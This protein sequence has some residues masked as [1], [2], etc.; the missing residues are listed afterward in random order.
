MRVCLTILSPVV[1]AQE[2]VSGSVYGSVGDHR[3]PASQFSDSGGDGS[4]AAERAAERV[5]RAQIDWRRERARE[6]EGLS[7]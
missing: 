5:E 1:G 2:V 7:L 6:R 4:T 3:L